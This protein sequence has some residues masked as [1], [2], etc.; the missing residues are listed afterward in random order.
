M[1]GVAAILDCYTV[2]PAGRTVM[3]S[4]S[5]KAATVR[6][7]S[8]WAAALAANRGYAVMHAA[9]S[10]EGTDLFAKYLAILAR[11]EPLVL[12][13][14]LVSELVYGPLAHGRSRLTLTMRYASRRLLLLPA[15]ASWFTSPASRSRLPRAC[16]PATGMPPP[17]RISGH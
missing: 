6:G 7:K 14:S 5:W 16:W 12:D 8:T 3:T 2:E 15:G 9:R 13:R 10:P 17:W 1:A 4:S 11:P